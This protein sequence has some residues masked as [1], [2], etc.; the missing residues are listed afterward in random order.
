MIPNLVKTTTVYYLTVSWGGEFRNSWV[1][2]SGPHTAAVKASAR[3][4]VSSAVGFSSK[5]MYLLTRVHLAVVELMAVRFSKTRRRQSIE[6]LEEGW[7]RRPTVAS[8]VWAQGTSQPFFK[9]SHLIKSAHPGQPPFWLMQ[10]QTGLVLS[11]CVQKSLHLCQV[12]KPNRGSDSHPIH[13]P[14]HTQIM[15]YQTG[16]VHLWKGAWGPF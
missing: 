9:R 5:L 15:G 6:T 10:S 16:R 3:S 11:L 14:A 12:I 4:G 13:G 1:F 2:C 7:G 8:G